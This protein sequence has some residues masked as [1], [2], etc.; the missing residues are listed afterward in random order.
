[1]N[2]GVTYAPDASISGSPLVTRSGAIS[3]TTPS[4]T[5]TSA[6]VAPAPVPSTSVPPRTSK[7]PCMPGSYV[8]VARARSVAICCSSRWRSSFPVPVRGSLARN[9]TRSGTLYAASRPHAKLR[10]AS[11][12]TDSP[13]SS[14]TYASSRSPRCSSGAPTT[15]ASATAGCWYSTS[16]APAHQ[17]GEGAP[18]VAGVAGDEPG[19][20]PDLVVGDA[21]DPVDQ[22]GMGDQRDRAGVLEREACLTLEVPV[23]ERHR[24]RVEH[25]TR[26]VELDELGAVGQEHRDAVARGDTLGAESPPATRRTRSTSSE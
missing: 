20:D 10:S 17:G 2:P 21:V 18:T 23:V 16:S 6:R 26:E 4:R 15:H 14:S 3:A 25:P 5:R 7:L 13:G 8:S 1:M 9:M 22:F 11:S 12:V 19:R 24:D